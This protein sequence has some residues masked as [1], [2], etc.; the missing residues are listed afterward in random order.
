VETSTDEEGSPLLH[1][2]IEEDEESSEG[3]G[4]RFGRYKSIIIHRLP[5][6]EAMKNGNGT[7]LI[8]YHYSTWRKLAASNYSY[9]VTNYFNAIRKLD[10]DSFSSKWSHSEYDEF[11]TAHLIAAAREVR[12]C[13]GKVI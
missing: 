3:E 10:F 13:N 11:I 4:R 8:H 2:Q 9:L 12:N 7:S 1:D 5:L 6:Q